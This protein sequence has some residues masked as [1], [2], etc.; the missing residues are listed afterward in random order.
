MAAIPFCL[1]VLPLTFSGVRASAAPEKTG[2][3]IY[4][5]MCLS[6][7]GPNGEGS[8]ETERALTGP[9]TIPQLARVIAKTMPDDDPGTCVGPDAEKVAAYI[10]DAFYSPAA[11][12]RNKPPRVELA[13][14][15]VK[16]YRNAVTDL[17]GS[18]RST[19]VWDKERGLHGEYFSSRR[20]ST[21]D[22]QIDRRD[23]Q[24]AF[25]FG[26]AAPSP[27]KFEPHE[28][29]I[30][31]EGS[32]L[33]PETGEYEFIVR[34]EHAA[35]LWVNDTRVAMIDA[36]VKSGNDTEYRQS[37]RLLGGRAY[38][39]RLEFSKAK[40][41]VNDQ[42]KDKPKPPSVKAS[43][44]L[45]WKPPQRAEE[46]IP[47]RNLTPNRF[48]E[49]LVIAT[50][51]PPDDRS[52]GYERG[53]SVSKA[54]DQ[55]ATDAAI[56]VAGYV[57]GH[58]RELSGV[59]EEGQDREKRLKE[60]CFKFA[61]RAFRRPLTDEQKAL[62]VERQFT[63]SASLDLAVKRVVMLVLMSPRF[64]YREAE[65]SST[66]DPYDVA[67]R[68]SFALWDAPP[69]SKLLE[70]A[71]GGRLATR[72]QIVA[73]AERMLGDLRA[74]AK[75]RDFLL[76]WLKVEQA[77][78]IS[79]DPE[80]FPGFDAAVIS[81]LRTSLELFM[82][83]V[84]WGPRSDFRQ[85]LLA[86][87]VYLNGRLA[88]YYGAELPADAP[89]QKY[90]LN[91]LERA[92][93][94]SHPYLMAMFAYTATSSPIHRG[95]FLVRGIMGR[96]LR[97]PPIAVAPL[98]PDLHAGLTTRERIALQTSPEACQT[99]HTTINPLG[100]GL[101]HFDAVGRYRSE[102]KGKPIDATGYF[103]TAT[104]G[105]ANFNGVRELAT[106]LAEGDEASAAFAEQLFHYMI[107]QPIR[108]F[109]VRKASELRRLFARSDYNI[110]QLMVEIVAS[111]AI[112]PQAIATTSRD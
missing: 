48:P 11:Q 5:E 17:V 56:E 85:F 19:G 75:L 31:W 53:T 65:E 99:C 40:Q 41:G 81:D 54:W 12:E 27:E 100:F 71:A 22:R 89:F 34:T 2:E 59:G 50:P 72:E 84:A 67:S 16:Q 106:L 45:L 104:G 74:R 76:Q 33:A 63:E 97:T 91:P 23:P 49:S 58:L 9:R 52:V 101:E 78:D 83:E 6:C 28:F 7:H 25:D 94:L 32:V 57:A 37:I 70:A 79:K 36:W 29:S 92:G 102:E 112:P 96:G 95:V 55:A 105:T 111:T 60:F 107:K 39:I 77:P 82:D 46:V 21:R 15:T 26:E 13:R 108:A 44:A 20:F 87:Y 42:K 93:V 35:R 73:Q 110:R 24:V 88:Q 3:Q 64:L 86:D 51:F 10:F 62:Y 69:D 61:E 109:G 4:K 30:R 98:A 18:F 47:E 38:P 68:I 14:L 8:E 90:T 43:I 80:K 103:E 66:P 1:F